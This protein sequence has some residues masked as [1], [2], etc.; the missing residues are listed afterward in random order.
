MIGSAISW[1]FPLNHLPQE[2]ERKTLIVVCTVVQNYS[3]VQGKRLCKRDANIFVGD[4][5]TSAGM[6]KKP[7][8]KKFLPNVTQVVGTELEW[9]IKRLIANLEQSG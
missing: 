4:L 3:P 5:S 6:K 2:S 7:E 1:G 8:R 9:D